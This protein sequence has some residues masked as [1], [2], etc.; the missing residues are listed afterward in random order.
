MPKRSKPS[1]QGKL[2]RAEDRHPPHDEYKGPLIDPLPDPSPLASEM[3]RGEWQEKLNIR[4]RLLM[5]HFGIDP[6]DTFAWVKLASELARRHVPGFMP[7]GK[8]PGRPPERDD[9][10]LWFLFELLKRRDGLTDRAASEAIALACNEKSCTIRRRYGRWKERHSVQVEFFQWMTEQIG[11]CRLIA[12]L[13][14]GVGR[15]LQKK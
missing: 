8:K 7:S 3:E 9:V 6:E 1:Q 5:Q 4:M 2:A 14:G 10:T 11:A 13:E 12:H 15:L